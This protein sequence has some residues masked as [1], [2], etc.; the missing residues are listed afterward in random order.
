MRHCGWS[1]DCVCI[2]RRVG[3]DVQMAALSWEGEREGRRKRA[4]EGE[5]A[6]LLVFSKVKPTTPASSSNSS[7]GTIVVVVV[8]VVDI[9]CLLVVRSSSRSGNTHHSSWDGTGLGSHRPVA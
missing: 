3:N 2:I 9:A 5:I 4:I 6:C 7:S 1:V 8:V